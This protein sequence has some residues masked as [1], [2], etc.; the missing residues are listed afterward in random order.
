MRQQSL[1][2]CYACKQVDLEPHQLNPAQNHRP[3]RTNSQT[4]F[5]QNVDHILHKIF[6][7]CSPKINKLKI[8]HLN[9]HAAVQLH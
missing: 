3:G 1:K 9:V 8:I 4:R 2:C 6:V 5:V 7:R